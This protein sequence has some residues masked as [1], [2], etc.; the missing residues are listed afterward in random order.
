MVVTEGMRIPGV[1]LEDGRI[2]YPLVFLVLLVPVKEDG[3]AAAHDGEKNK[4]R[5]ANLCLYMSARS[6][7]VT[8]TNDQ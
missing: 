4:G 5:D 2:L 6:V 1:A 3:H 7:S 8:R